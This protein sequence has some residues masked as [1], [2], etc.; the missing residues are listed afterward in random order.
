MDRELEKLEANRKLIARIQDSIDDPGELSDWECE[1]LES[2]KEQ[3][4]KGYTLSDREGGQMDTLEK[5]EYKRTEGSDAY[6]REFGVGEDG[7]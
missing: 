3:V 6:W 4:V 5:I 2:I 7:R 1:F